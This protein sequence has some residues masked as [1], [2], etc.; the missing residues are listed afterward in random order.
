MLVYHTESCHKGDSKP[1]TVSIK[2][3]RMA[4]GEKMHIYLSKTPRCSCESKTEKYVSQ[5][6][7]EEDTGKKKKQLWEGVHRQRLDE[8]PPQEYLCS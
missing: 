1:S 3:G 6:E 4:T 2:A 7:E 5:R 8:N